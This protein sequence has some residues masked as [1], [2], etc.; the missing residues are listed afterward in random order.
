MGELKTTTRTK[1]LIQRIH[2]IHEG[3]R[4][5]FWLA[6]IFLVNKFRIYSFFPHLLIQKTMV[7]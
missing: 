5:F 3:Y 2:A 6:I 1:K 4:S 7:L